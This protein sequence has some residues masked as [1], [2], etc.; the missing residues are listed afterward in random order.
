MPLV[1]NGNVDQCGT[2]H[3]EDVTTQVYK[4]SN[5]YQYGYEYISINLHFEII[6]RFQEQWSPIRQIS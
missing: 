4:L 5:S 3:A 6:Q 2:R 1:I